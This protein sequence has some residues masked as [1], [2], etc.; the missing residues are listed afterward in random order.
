MLLIVWL[1]FDISVWKIDSVDGWKE[2]VYVCVVMLL[3]L[4]L[5]YVNDFKVCLVILLMIVE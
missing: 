3:L 5:I 4:V 2:G 1:L